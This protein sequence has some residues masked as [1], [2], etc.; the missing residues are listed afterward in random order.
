MGFSP[1]VQNN[2]TS[3]QPV[4]LSQPAQMNPYPTDGSS[5]NLPS[6]SG[7]VTFPGMSGQPKVGSPNQYTNTVSQWDNQTQIDPTKMI[8]KGA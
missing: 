1:T 7:S 4:P 2:Q 6:M 3:G 8:G 5:G